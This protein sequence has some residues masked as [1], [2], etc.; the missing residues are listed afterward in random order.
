VAC[1]GRGDLGQLGTGARV[2]SVG[3]T[4]PTMPPH[5]VL[6]GEAVRARWVTL[7]ARWVTLRAPWVTL[8]ARWVTLRALA[9]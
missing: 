7:R 5:A 4:A 9:G 6:L 2:L 8:R 1:W 3:V